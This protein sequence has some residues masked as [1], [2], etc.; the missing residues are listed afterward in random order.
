[1]K[2]VVA[3]V[4][5][6]NVGKSSLFNRLTR[7]RRSIVA[8]YA[9]V[10]RDRIYVEA[11]L[12]DLPVVLVDTGG[13]DPGSEDPI[14]RRVLEQT[15]L[16]IDEADVVLFM[17][18]GRA[19][20]LPEDF[21]IARLLLQSGKLT[22][23][24]VNK[25]D[26]PSHDT[27]L[28]EFHR[29]G[30]PDLLPVSAAH[31]R[32]VGELEELVRARLVAE[33]ASDASA[34][35]EPSPDER[36]D[37]D[38]A[39]EGEDDAAMIRVAVIGRPNVG[40]S[41]LV[42]RLLGE[43]RHLV[44]NVA[45]T[46]VDSVDSLV[47]WRGQPFV[48]VDTAGIRRK[49][50]IAHR[51][52]R[53]SVFKALEGLDRSDVALL[54]IDPTQPVAHQ[55]AR[56]SEYAAE[57]GKSVVLVVSKWDAVSEVDRKTYEAE[58]RREMPHLDYAPVVF[59]SSHTGSG[60]DRLFPAIRKVHRAGGLRVSTA[61]LNR[62]A[63]E[64]MERNPPPSKKGKSA[65]I[66]YLTQVG[67]RP[68]RFMASVN[69][70]SLIHFSYRR[71]LINE[72]RRAYGFEGAPIVMSFRSHDREAPGAE[73]RVERGKARAAEHETK[74]ATAAR[75]AKKAGKRAT[76]SSKAIGPRK[77]KRKTSIKRRTD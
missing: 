67:V 76:G 44:S 42:N 58:L 24:A 56:V 46:T 20:P 47:E 19:G 68:P 5:R 13:F 57:H 36:F 30:L 74:K 49:R 35:P 8:D 7:S 12:D 51:I 18:D 25:L 66:Y 73:A 23:V 48:F 60:F 14:M 61:R 29:L 62:F 65:R 38:E 45:G 41:S 71:F 2:P 9:G 10:T 37:A 70:P 4:G 43:D 1:M 40:K 15:Q 39:A 32:N 28:Y 59:T 21:D 17:T 69:N 75:R 11:E 31:G 64:I 27:L 3:I 53:F 63:Q 50:S 34:E 16:A 54:L 55:D 26:G 6:P 72:L 52:E 33:A 22:V 77:P